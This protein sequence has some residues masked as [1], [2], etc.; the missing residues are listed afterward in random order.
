[1][2]QLGGCVWLARF[3]DKARLH[4]T[5]SLDDEYAKVFCHPHSTDGAFLKHFSIDKEEIIA[6]IAQSKGQDEPVERWFVE[7]SRCSPARIAEWNVLAPNLGKEGY[8]MRRAFVWA[9]K[10]LYGDDEDMK[11][12]S[13]FSAIAR[14]EGYLDS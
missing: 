8:P 3:V 11:V 9:R 14:D 2:E 1:M 5:D 4:L 12:D 7:E 6:V 13:V 10:N